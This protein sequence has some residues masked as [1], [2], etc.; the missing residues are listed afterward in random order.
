MIPSLRRQ[1]LLSAGAVVIGAFAVLGVSLYL[2]VRA[3]LIAELD[4]G[5]LAEAEALRAAT[6]FHRADEDGNP[7]AND[8][9]IDFDGRQPAQFI[10]GGKHPHYF[11][12]WSADKAVARSPSLAGR[13]LKWLKSAPG[14]RYIASTCCPTAPAGGK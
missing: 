4:R 6:E 10:P 7:V 12:L 9:R 13:D 8:V 5:L 14:D 1:I 11:E 2:F 3:W